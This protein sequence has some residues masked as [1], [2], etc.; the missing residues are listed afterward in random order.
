M[1]RNGHRTVL[2]MSLHFSPRPSDF[3]SLCA[4]ADKQHTHPQGLSRWG[5]K[6]QVL[7]LQVARHKSENLNFI[8]VKD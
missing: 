8:S 1:Q 4:A 5:E 7:D 3:H 6:T 2:I